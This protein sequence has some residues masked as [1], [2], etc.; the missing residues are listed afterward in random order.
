MDEA[1]AIT[2]LEHSKANNNNNNKDDD[3]DN[4]N[5]NNNKEA[6]VVDE[7]AIAMV[8][9]EWAGIPL[10]K[11][12]RAE[13]DRLVQLEEDL[14]RRVKGQDRAIQSVSR[15]VRR[16][17]SGLRDPGRP[18]AS[19][20]F[21]GPTG[22]GKTELCKTLAETYFGSEKDMIRIDMSEYMEKHSV[23]RL[24]GPPPGY[25]GYVRS[26]YYFLCI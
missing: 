6:P 8:I 26:Y 25:I 10:G 14:T 16:A 20:L 18:I 3:D 2:H 23:A 15:A 17:R 13:Q 4:D 5:D 1:G 12:E 7:H 19:F 11:L 22:T 24:T 21:C 9:S